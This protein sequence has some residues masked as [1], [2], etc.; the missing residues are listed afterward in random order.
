MKEWR[1]TEHEILEA[2][3]TYGGGFVKQLAVLYRLGDAINR[4]KLVEAFPDYFQQYD[5]M[6]AMAQ[7]ERL[8]P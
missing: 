4:R 5:E 7:R 3:W 1:S 8:A 2:M 6:A